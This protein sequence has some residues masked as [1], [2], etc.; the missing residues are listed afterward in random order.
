SSQNRID[1]V[2]YVMECYDFFRKIMIISKKSSFSKSKKLKKV[3][4]EKSP[5]IEK[6]SKQLETT[7]F[8]NFPVE[9]GVL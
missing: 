3:E 8:G 5:K 4:I 7:V 1:L 9:L 2:T 6:K